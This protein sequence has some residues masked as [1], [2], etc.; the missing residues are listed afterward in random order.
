MEELKPC[1]CCGHPAEI[2]EDCDDA[3]ITF[4]SVGCSHCT[5]GTDWL[6]KRD[7]CISHWN[8]RSEP[9][10]LPEWVLKLLRDTM[11]L[12]KPTDTPEFR[13]GYVAAVEWFLSLR[14]PE[15]NE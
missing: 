4:Y 11:Y 12:F 15:E 6:Y 9:D 1:P 13:E 10:E 2:W 3:G 8:A 7:D 5:I 14:K